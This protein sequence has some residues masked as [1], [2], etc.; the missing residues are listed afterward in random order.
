MSKFKGEGWWIGFKDRHPELSL[1]TADPL[2]MVHVN[3]M[4]QETF[5]AYFDLL[6]KTLTDNGLLNKASAIYNMDESGM[7]LDHK[8][9]KRVAK[10]G[11]KKVYGRASGNKM[12]I[13]IVAC[14]NAAGHTLP[15]MII[16][17]GEHLNHDY[18]KVEVPNTL[19]GMSKQGWIDSELFY[20]W[21]SNLFVPNI[22]PAR[23]VLLLLDGHSTH[24]TPEAVRKAHDEGI[25][26]LCLPPHTT[27]TA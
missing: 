19:Y 26:M 24:Y 15:P 23:P 12:Q 5:D 13:T 9:L 25:I 20:C 11:T 6:E 2:S 8:Q 7:P 18:T 17:K 4:T 3:A 22:P 1:R 10:R 14:A 27:H 21:L 16:F